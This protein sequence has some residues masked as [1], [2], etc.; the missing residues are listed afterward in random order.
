MRQMP[1]L[2]GDTSSCVR[3]C[4]RALPLVAGLAM[5]FWCVECPRASAADDPAAAR[6]DDEVQPIL[7]QYCYGCHGMGSK[8]GG[9]SLDGFASAAA[10]ASARELWHNVLRN[11][12]TGIMPPPGK[13]KPSAH[14]FKTLETWIKRDA[15]QDDPNDPD[16]GRVTLRRLNRVEY[17]NTIRD[18][19]GIDFR[20]DEEFPADDAGYGFDNIGDVLTVSPLLLEKYLQ[21]AESI[22]AKAVPTV[23]KAVAVRVLNGTDFRGENDAK[24]DRLSFYKAANVAQTFHAPHD[25]T[26]RLSVVL[27]VDG[28]FNPE[29]GKCRFTLLDND[30]E[31]WS[32]DFIWGDNQVFR[33]ELTQTWKAGDHRLAFNLAPT[34][35]DG[36]KTT[37]LDMLVRSVTVEGPTEP[38]FWERPRNWDRFFTQNDPGS[39][40]GRRPY[41]R[42]VLREIASKAFR[43]PV[44][45]RMLDRLVTI[46]ES[47]YQ[48][49]GKTVEQGVGQA[50][51]VIL[52]SPRFLFRVEG[53]ESVA[54]G[55][56]SAPIDEYSL[57]SRLSYFLWSSMPDAELS[58]L[59]A[60]SGLRKALKPQVERMLTD[61][62]SEALVENFTGQWLESRDIE[63]FPIQ[64]RTILRQDGLPSRPDTEIAALRR[65]MKR[66]IEMTFAHVVRDDRSVLEFLDSDYTFANEDLARLY[67]IPGVTGKEFRRVT[68]PENSPRGGL[69]TQAGVLMITSNPSRTS[70][71]KRGQF[72]LD[73]FLGSPT[74]PP[75]PEIPPLE[76]AQRGIKDHQ[77]TVREVMALHRSNALCASCHARMDPLGLALENFNALGIWRDSER[78]QPI[79]ASGQLL[80]GQTFKDVRDLKKILRGDLRRDFYRRLTEKLLT[81][82]LGR[83]LDYHDVETVDQIVDRLERNDGRFSDLLMGIIES[84]PFQKR[85][86]APLATAST[87]PFPAPKTGDHP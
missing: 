9:V 50:L 61:P 56:A 20:A 64:A 60:R 24:G 87:Q 44:D 85:R 73:N 41:A 35:P 11:V 6:F 77:P 16:P 13:P 72:I 66:E 34:T 43:R 22:V 51:V 36:A 78:Q 4:A 26:Y 45:E 28:P 15:F 59:A 83:G 31:L 29:P 69:L 17:R 54:A 18:L 81:Y 48:E 12:R 19:M 1:G 40:E 53:S 70:P 47:T 65:L 23:S 86:V 10:A 63:H 80:S 7:E 82:A 84:A 30:R 49:P 79:D 57:A 75:P 39:L 5:V 52:A 76:E 8:K 74:P 42:K 58:S 33:Y 62:K 55:R 25:G 3:T 14:E 32:E 38:E 71:V 46:A 21:A 2:S 68:L 37:R 67:G 27:E